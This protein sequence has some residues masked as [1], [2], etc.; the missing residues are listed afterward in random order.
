MGPCTSTGPSSVTVT[1]RRT[2]SVGTPGS[3]DHEFLVA[4]P[5]FDESA[6]FE[7][8]G[9]QA[10]NG[11]KGHRAAGE[12]LGL[13]AGAGKVAE[14]DAVVTHGG[15]DKQHHAPRREENGSFGADAV[16]HDTSVDATIPAASD[17]MSGQYGRSRRDVGRIGQDEVVV[18]ACHR[19]A[20][21][22]APHGARNTAQAAVEPGGYH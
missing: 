1:W 4:L 12:H 9:T 11:A 13:Q 17:P 8:G 19:F 5:G 16:Q 10:H 6:G 20:Q 15:V 22:A 7:H 18:L 3:N 21:V 2:G 14:G